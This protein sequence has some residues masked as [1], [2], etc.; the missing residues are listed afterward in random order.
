M[1]SVAPQPNDEPDQ[2]AEQ[3]EHEDPAPRHARLVAKAA[4]GHTVHAED[5]ASGSLRRPPPVKDLVERLMG[6]D[7]G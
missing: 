1:A 5:D 3:E 6:R 2:D 7:R 4:A